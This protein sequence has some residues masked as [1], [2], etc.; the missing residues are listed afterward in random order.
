M[1]I[2][3]QTLLNQVDLKHNKTSDSRTLNK[4]NTI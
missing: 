2:Y 1:N 3:I 4:D